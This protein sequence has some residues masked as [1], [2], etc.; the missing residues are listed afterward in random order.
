MSEPEGRADDRS[1]SVSIQVTFDCAG[2]DRLA[3]FSA[4]AL[5]HIMQRPPDWIV[6]QVPE[7]N[8]LCLQ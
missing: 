5:D 6:M 7:G 2:P 3:R 4:E 1:G 8:E